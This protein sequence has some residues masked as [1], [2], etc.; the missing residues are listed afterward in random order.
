[1]VLPAKEI[2]NIG[3][4][5]NGWRNT[6]NATH[7]FRNSSEEFRITLEKGS[8]HFLKLLGECLTSLARVFKDL[9]LDQPKQS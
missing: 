2:K 6:M 9:A 7:K 8:R 5:C 4:V 3:D 1:M